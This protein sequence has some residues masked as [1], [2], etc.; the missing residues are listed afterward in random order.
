MIAVLLCAGYATRL[1]PLTRDFPKPLLPVA[2]RPVLDYLMDPLTVMEGLR[3]IHLVTNTRFIRHFKTWGEGWRNRLE[4]AG[5]GLILHNDGSTANANRR[6]A[7]VD[8]ELALGRAADPEGIL[9]A[10]GDNIFL[11]DLMPL[12]TAFCGGACHRIVVLPERD[13]ARLRKTGVPVFGQGDRVR[14][15]VEKPE[16][17]PS[18]WCC[19]PIYFLKPS[20]R[21][22]LADF[23]QNG[24]NTD[25]PGHFINYLCR[26]EHVEAFRLDATRLDIGDE[27]SYRRADRLMNVSRQKDRG[28]APD[29]PKG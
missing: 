1:Y 13:A 25:A 22:M 7:C 26:Q 14:A 2:D 18:Q 21:S 3:E 4:T 23:L 16:K 19:P 15:V 24:E 11:F 17:P 20:A 10:A 28:R 29:S 6:G 8:L 27:A 9:V 12:W 5:I